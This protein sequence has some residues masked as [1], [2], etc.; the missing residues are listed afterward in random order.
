M[1]LIAQEHN[2]RGFPDPAQ[3]IPSSY[4]IGKSR[5]DAPVDEWRRLMIQASPMAGC[6]SRLLDLKINLRKK[7]IGGQCRRNS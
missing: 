1:P 4:A 5:F 2:G 7:N 3:R 6:G